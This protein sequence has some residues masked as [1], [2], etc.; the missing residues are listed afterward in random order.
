MKPLPYDKVKQ[1]IPGFD[2]RVT[3]SSVSLEMIAQGKYLLRNIPYRNTILPIVE[4]NT[5]PL[6]GGKREVHTYWCNYES[7]GWK[8]PDAELLYQ[9][10]RACD[11]QRSNPSLSEVVT[12]FSQ[13]M[14]DILLDGPNLSTVSVVQYLRTRSL[15]V[16]QV[17]LLPSYGISNGGEVPIPSVVQSTLPGWRDFIPIP[18]CRY[19]ADTRSRSVV[20]FSDD[21]KPLLETLLGQGYDQVGM[22]LSN[23][24]V[25][26]DSESKLY[27][28]NVGTL[29]RKGHKSEV[30]FGM[31]EGNPTHL[32]MTCFGDIDE[33]KN[34]AVS[35]R[36]V[37]S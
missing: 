7:E 8:V 25:N 34:I 30:T 31:M 19:D 37:N 27:L 35:V 20:S 17:G 21:T 4:F 26:D 13:E 36:L 32:C 1:L 16:A 22:V 23:L 2:T 33:E 6:E 5:S 9:V 24:D 28:F 18:L 3:E 12:Q 11:D 14:Q 10:L 29:G 15:Y